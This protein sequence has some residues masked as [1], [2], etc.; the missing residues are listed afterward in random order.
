[1]QQ[2]QGVLALSRFT[3]EKQL[4]M[5]I[6]VQHSSKCAAVRWCMLVVW[7]RHGHKTVPG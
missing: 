7:L 5:H 2:H 4:R 1:M 3:Q 6:S